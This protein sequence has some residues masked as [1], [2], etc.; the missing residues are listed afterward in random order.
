MEFMKVGFCL[1]DELMELWKVVGVFLLVRRTEGVQEGGIFWGGDGVLQ[2][3]E[4]REDGVH[5]GRILQPDELMEF[6]KVRSKL[7]H[8]RFCTSPTNSW[9]S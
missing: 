5:E 2:P 4:L 1:S 6:M 8:G 7:R 3:D 9:S